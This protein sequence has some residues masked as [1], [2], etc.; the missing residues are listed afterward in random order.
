[1]YRRTKANASQVWIGCLWHTF[2]YRL[3]AVEY[4]IELLDAM[5]GWSAVQGAG[6]RYG[7]GF[8]M[9]Q[10]RFWLQRIAVCFEA[11]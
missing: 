7:A 8:T 3:R 5:G 1:M 4:P 6:W 10:K 9:E 11:D 2:R